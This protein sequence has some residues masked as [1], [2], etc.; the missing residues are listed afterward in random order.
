MDTGFI[1]QIAATVLNKVFIYDIP[2]YYCDSHGYTGVVR[3]VVKRIENTVINKSFATIICTEERKQ[4]IYPAR[5]KRL[6]VIHNTPDLE[7]DTANIIQSPRIRLVY[8]GIFGKAR[9]IDRIAEIVSRRND[10][11]F[12]IGGYGAN[13]ESYFENMAKSNENIYYYGRLLYEDTLKLEKSCDVICAIYD[14]QIAN[15]RY[16]APNKFYEAL[17]LG[18]PL[19]MA[20]NTGMAS[21]VEQQNLGETIEYSDEGFNRAIDKLILRKA[22]WKSIGEREQALYKSFYSWKKMESKIFELYKDVEK[23]ATRRRLK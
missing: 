18:K 2:D 9:F 4:Q 10:C 12:H 5:P 19:I 8:V 20:Q 11:E 22:E 23:E 17:A 14:P 1:A 15:H 3:K 16:A 21:I 7:V 6:I 13:M